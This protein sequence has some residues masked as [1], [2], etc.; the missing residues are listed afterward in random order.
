MI[1]W[2]ETIGRLSLHWILDHQICYITRIL[3]DQN[4]KNFDRRMILEVSYG[5]LKE[6]INYKIIDVTVD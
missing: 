1:R 2:H 5:Y 4:G 3:L 6:M